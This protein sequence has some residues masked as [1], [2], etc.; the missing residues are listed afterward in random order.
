VKWD[1]TYSACS[2][3]AVAE[4]WPAASNATITVDV[5]ND[6]ADDHLIDNLVTMTGTNYKISE[7]IICSLTRDTAVANDYA[8]NAYL[9]SVDVHYEVDTMGSRQTLAK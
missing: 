7:V 6:S 3:V 1:T 9:V 5:Q 2:P 8:T 4:S